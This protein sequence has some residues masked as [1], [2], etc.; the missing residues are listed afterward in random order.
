MHFCQF[1]M[2]DCLLSKMCSK[3][4]AAVIGGILIH[5]TLGNLYSFGN[6]MTYMASYMHVRVD[7]SIDYGNFIWVNSITTAAQGCF[8][9][10]GG[11]LEKKVGPKITCFVGCTLLSG[12]QIGK[13]LSMG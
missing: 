7:S 5:L 4:I 2:A 11:L 10:F 3:G 1:K 6:M 12:I 9:V 8:M 13:V